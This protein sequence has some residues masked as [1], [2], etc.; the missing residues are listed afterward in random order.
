M[1]DKP[2]APMPK[3]GGILTL[4]IRDKGALYSAY[5]PFIKNGGIFVPTNKNYQVSEEVFMLMT[6]MEEK[7]KIPVAGRVAWMTPKGAQGNRLAGIGIQFS[8]QDGGAVRNKIETYL[9]GA[10][11]SDRSTYTM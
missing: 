2:A 10:L 9:A 7:E 5:M 6:L 8:D 3:Q 1:S 4:T 11:K